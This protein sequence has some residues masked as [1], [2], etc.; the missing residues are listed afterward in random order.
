MRHPP[1]VTK[2]LDSALTYFALAQ[3]FRQTM[4]TFQ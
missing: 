3:A 2:L 4:E 1:S